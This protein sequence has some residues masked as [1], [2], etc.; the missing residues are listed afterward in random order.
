[1]VRDNNEESILR[2]CRDQLWHKRTDEDRTMRIDPRVVQYR[3]E[4]L[5]FFRRSEDKNTVIY[6]IIS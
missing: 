3:H 5:R 6:H 4:F 2:I 1:M